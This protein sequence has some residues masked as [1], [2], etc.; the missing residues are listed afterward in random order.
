MK[1]HHND[2]VSIEYKLNQIVYLI[3]LKHITIYYLN[4]NFF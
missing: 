1:D 4:T 2:V 3:D